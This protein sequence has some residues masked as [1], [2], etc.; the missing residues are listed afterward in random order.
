MTDFIFLG[1]KK[2]LAPWKEGCDKPRQYIKKQTSLC[3]QKVCIVKAIVFPVVM[4]GCGS[5]TIKKVECW[6]MNAFELW[7]WRRLLRVPGTARLNQSVLKEINPEYSLEKLMPNLQ[8]FS[9]VIWRA[10]VLQKTLML[11]KTEGRRRKGRQ[12]EMVG[13]HH[14]HNGHEIEQ[15][16]GD[17]GG[18]RSLICYSP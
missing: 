10:S 4:S 14:W 17:S 15:I 9:H 6:R 11:G 13:W 12:D 16:P 18:Q 7:C 1:S 5:W 2:T 8:Y 3:W